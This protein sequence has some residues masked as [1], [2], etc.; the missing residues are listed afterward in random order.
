LILLRGENG[1][2]LFGGELGLC[3][4]NPFFVWELESE[5]ATSRRRREIESARR[6]EF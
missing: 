6:R 3:L 1:L 2:G 4:L 5:R